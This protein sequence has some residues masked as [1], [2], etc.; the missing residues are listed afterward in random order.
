[1]NIEE[2]RVTVANARSV[3]IRP[4]EIPYPLTDIHCQIGYRNGIAHIKHIS[5]VHDVS[6]LSANGDFAIAADGTWTGVMRWLPESRLIVDQ[7]LLSCLPGYLQQPIL[8]TAFRGPISVMGETRFASSADGKS[9]VMRDCDLE[10]AIEEGRL[11]WG[12]IASGIRGSVH[13]VGS[14]DDINISAVG[15]LKLD[16]LSI[17]GVPVLDLRGPFILH[18]G[19]LYFGRECR[20]VSEQLASARKNSPFDLLRTK[21]VL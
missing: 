5:G 15:D 9:M 21:Q 10:L 8:S 7:S 14:Y 13:V 11:G 2:Q 20:A 6:R 12:E 17:Y 19:N 1:M 4:R 18:A 3:S 16:S